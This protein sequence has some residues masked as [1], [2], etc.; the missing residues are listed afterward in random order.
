MERKRW[1]GKIELDMKRKKRNK[2][3][4]EKKNQRGKSEGKKEGTF[5]P[6]K[7]TSKIHPLCVG[8]NRRLFRLH[9]FGSVK[10]R[11]DGWSSRS[12]CYKEN[13]LLA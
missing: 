9:H 4:W 10:N 2:K 3:R 11:F 12:Q 5:F 6:H 13:L 7:N 1:Q 8:L